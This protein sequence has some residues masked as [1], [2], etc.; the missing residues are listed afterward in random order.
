MRTHRPVRGRRILA[1][2][3]VC[4]STLSF[5]FVQPEPSRPGERQPEIDRPQPAQIRERLQSRLEWARSF[6][7]RLESGLRELDQGDEIDPALWREVLRAGGEGMRARPGEPTA[8]EP[9]PG[10]GGGPGWQFRDRGGEQREAPTL[11]EM[12]AFIN[13]RTPWLAERLAR[14]DEK[15]PNS[16]DRVIMGFA[17]RIAEIMQQTHDDPEA[18]EL[19]IEQF[20]LGADIVDEARRIRQAVAAGEMTEDE[21]RSAWR[22]LAERHVDIRERLTRHEADQTRARLAELEAQLASDTEKR[23]QMIEE[24]AD[25][26]FRRSMMRDRRD[27]HRPEDDPRE[28][29]PDGD[30]RGPGG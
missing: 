16:S 24:M 28:G 1:A 4:F 25:R 19:F 5:G 23:S 14:A 18:A 15:Y 29:R 30:R 21:A 11:E 26:M 22:S 20:R 8:R 7:D 13:E 10:E 3:L 12:K 9:G 2:T 27:D 17:P 6:V